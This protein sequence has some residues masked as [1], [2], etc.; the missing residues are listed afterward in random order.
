MAVI[1]RVE[2][3]LGP[4]HTALILFDTLNGYVVPKNNPKRLAYL[5]EHK[6][7]PNLTRLLKGARAAGLTT[8]YPMGV[9]APDGSDTVMRLTDTDINLNPLHGKIAQIGA[10]LK[11]GSKEAQFPTAIKPA[12]DDVVITKHRWSAFFDTDLH[13]HLRMRNID[14]VILAGGSTDVGLISTIFSA[15]DLDLGIVIARDA[16]YSTRDPNQDFLMERIFP[17]MGRILS[18]DQTIELMKAGATKLK[19]K[20]KAK[21]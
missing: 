1:S 3:T 21:R 10:H 17:R 5:R 9:H 18:V 12:K 14:T 2:R 4:D 20:R 6:I 16:C 8:F 7:M 13:F 15:R 11:P 19:S